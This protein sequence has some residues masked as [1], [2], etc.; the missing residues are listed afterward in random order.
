[1]G[2]S[3]GRGNFLWF[4]VSMVCKHISFTS[5]YPCTLCQTCPI[6]EARR[7]APASN[8]RVISACSGKFALRA[9]C[10]NPLGLLPPSHSMPPGPVYNW[11][12]VAHSVVNILNHA[13][14]IKAAQMALRSGATT[15]T[16][17]VVLRRKRRRVEDM[18]REEVEERVYGGKES[19]VRCSLKW[20]QE[21]VQEVVR[22][23]KRE[24]VVEDNSIP[25]SV[26][27]GHPPIEVVIPSSGVK[28]VLQSP[29]ESKDIKPD[30]ASAVLGSEGAES[31]VES[32]TSSTDLPEVSSNYRICNACTKS[33]FP[34]SCF[35][36]L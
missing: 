10:V 21:E 6:C 29:V 25:E 5:P 13:A 27:D 20:V 8:I 24:L 16:Q 9:G 4:L 28:E 35:F 30:Q 34:H 22:P 7:D 23:V 26:K 17:D 32:N 3:S 33:L 14:Q 15:M 19:G 11:L 36:F 31:T 1:M 18:G 12:C 2:Q